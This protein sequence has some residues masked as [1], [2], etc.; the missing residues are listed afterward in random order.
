[1]QL[2]PPAL[3]YG[4]VL[5]FMLIFH[6]RSSSIK[7]S[8][9]SKVVIHQRS[10]SIKG[11]LPSKVVF[12]QRSS[13]IKGC[14]PSKVA[15]IKGCL[16]SKVVFHQRLSSNKGHVPS[17]VTF[18]QRV[19]YKLWR[20]FFNRARLGREA[21]KKYRKTETPWLYEKTFEGKRYYQPSCCLY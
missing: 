14:L 16:P 18:N 5:A 12:H 9:P 1:M 17:K 20:P 8:L 7:G 13:S 19:S 6:Q 2:H 3:H 11:R 21:I 15:S 10:S 4:I